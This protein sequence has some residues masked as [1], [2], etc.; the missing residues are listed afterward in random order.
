MSTK[1]KNSLRTIK[2]EISKKN[3]G[4]RPKFTGSIKISVH[5]FSELPAEEAT[6]R[7]ALHT[8]S[9]PIQKKKKNYI[10]VSGTWIL[11]TL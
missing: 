9:F 3:N 8:G 2:A 4:P 10:V 6:A 11:L 5:L 7:K 1:N